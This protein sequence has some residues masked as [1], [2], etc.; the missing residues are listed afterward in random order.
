MPLTMHRLEVGLEPYEDDYRLVINQK[1]ES[2]PDHE[3]AAQF[4]AVLNNKAG[5]NRLA[6]AVWVTQ[7]YW[8]GQIN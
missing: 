5:F 2:I 8:S 7:Y 6:P 1:P 4:G 3:L